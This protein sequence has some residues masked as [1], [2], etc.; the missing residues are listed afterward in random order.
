MNKNVFSSTSPHI[1]SIQTDK[2]TSST[3][4][5]HPGSV[6]V[7]KVRQETH[8]IVPHFLG[9]FFFGPILPLMRLYESLPSL[10]LAQTDDPLLQN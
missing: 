3:T 7:V 8:A 1:Q 9:L 4:A 6:T 10:T 2:N 5:D